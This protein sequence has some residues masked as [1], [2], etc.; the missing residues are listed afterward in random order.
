VNPVSFIKQPFL[1]E[2]DRW[3]LWFPVLVACGI[4][5]Y[6]AL[7]FEPPLPLTAATP[8]L[9]LLAFGLRAHLDLR[10]L[11]IGLFAFSLG[12]NAAQMETRI[13]TSPLL[14]DKLPPTSLTGML[15]RAEAMPEGSRLTLKH[16]SIKDMPKEMRPKSVRLKVRDDFTTLP[17]AGT[18]INIWGPLWPPSTPVAPN[19][20]DF[21]RQAFFNQLGATGMS[22]GE[23]R[24]RDSRYPTRFFWDGFFLMF[25]KARHTLTLM[26]VE[27]LTPPQ[28]AMTAALLSGNQS[29]IERDIMQDMRISGL[30]HLLSISGV[31]VSMMSLLVY[32]PLR[33]LLA[34]IPWVALRFP[35]K[36]FAATAAIVATALYTLLVGADAPTVRSALTTSI[37][38]IAMIL[39]RK[40]LSMRLVALAA[41]T[42]MIFM[43]HTVMGPS[44]QMSFAAVIAM[45]AAYEKRIDEVLKEGFS[46]DLPQWLRGTGKHI[47]DIMGTS[48]IATAATTPFTL[49]HF[50][51]FSFY[52]VIANMLAIPFTSFWIMP[53]LLLSYITAP[54]HA[55]GWFIKGAGWGVELLIQLAQEVASW[56]FSQFS[57]PSMPPLAFGLML[58]G[59]LWLCLWHKK[60]RWLGLAPLLLGF[61]YPFFVLTPSIFIAES[62]GLWA[63][64]LEDGRMATY[65]K[66]AEDFTFHQW[67]QRS[68]NPDTLY[69]TKKKLPDPDI[70]D[71]SCDAEYCAYENGA[72]TVLFLLAGAT[73]ET[74]QKACLH[75]DYIIVASSTLPDC[76]GQIVI[77]ATSL[78]EH[79]AHTIGFEAD[80]RIKVD[81]TR[82]R[83][84][85]RPWSVGWVTST[86]R[87][88]APQATEKPIQ[89]P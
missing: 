7:P 6:F 50:Q 14:E 15:V 40:A 34:L 26:A 48:L 38:L 49:F 77:D 35:I 13:L 5:V 67:R 74:I 70:K 39:D 3:F 61:L 10:P 75:T 44:F 16:V 55:A 73:P 81:V 19:D 83:R 20:Y 36:K 11:L 87:G 89:Q 17:E 59:G 43:P 31:H 68:G 80:G 54:F 30:S 76:K 45:I 32:I 66:R 12:F 23:I 60:W 63:V 41:T 24:E 58:G 42:I 65:G 27:N 2:R 69:F 82:T 25:E 56:P 29:G 21:R 79:G 53:C 86:T 33:F 8:L 71:L 72:H 51:T 52:G 88:M 47:R 78:Y 85:Q 62:D 9:A 18:R 4:A 84:G 22:Y 28:L 46:L 1:D 37:I 64:R 57:A